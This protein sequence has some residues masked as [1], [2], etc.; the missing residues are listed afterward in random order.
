MNFLTPAFL[1]GAL[2]LALPVVLHL[3]RRRT[4]ERLPFSSLLFLSPT[5]PRLTKRSRLEDLL[6]LLLR[7][8]ALALLTFGFARPFLK[9]PSVAEPVSGQPRRLVVL[10][11]RSASMQRAGLWSAALA[12]AADILGHTTPGDQVA[13][14]AFDHEV[15]RLVSFEDWQ[16]APPGDRAALARGK[17]EALKPGWGATQLG[18]TL[19]AAAEMVTEA[20]V[21]QATPLRQIVLLSDVQE[22]GRLEKLQAY[23]WPKNLQL[24]VPPLKAKSPGN[25]GVQIVAEAADTSLTNSAVR[26]RVSNAPEATQ[27]QFQV[28]WAEA[29]DTFVGPASDVYVPPGQSR[30]VALPLPPPAAP[31][32]PPTRRVQLRGDDE[33]FDN[34]AY[35]IPPEPTTLRVLYLG[36]DAAGDARQ[37]LFFLRRALPDSPRQRVTLDARTGQA[38]LSAGDVAAAGL[39]L[40][41][42][43]LSAPTAGL[44]REAALA[45][46]TILFAPV[47]AAAGAPLATLLGVAAL[48]L[49]E[50][51]V[52]NY[53]MLAELDFE[54]PL[55]APFA[56]PRFS[57]FTKI[58]VWK[59]RVLDWASVPSARVLARFDS[60]SPALAEVPVG[61]GR[62]IILT[63]GWQPEDSQLALSTKFVPLLLSLLDYA[64]ATAGLAPAQPL[65]GEPLALRA[66]GQQVMLPD[67]TSVALAAGA[68][69]FTGTTQPGFYRVE[70]GGAPQ[71]FAVN[72]DPNESRTAPWSADVFETYGIGTANPLAAAPASALRKTQLQA[73]ESESRQKLWRWFLLATLLVLLIETALAGW[74]AR[75]ALPTEAT[76]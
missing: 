32:V 60:G 52:K 66:G 21:Q 73:A 30:V 48:P 68:T 13:V 35:V 71:W 15:N 56:D 23:D 33:P 72:L 5:P 40:V 9:N 19:I 12:Q 34:V 17:L 45:G 42:G 7:C 27:E 36:A 16:A 11:D 1:F 64:G 58:H 74:T 76:A 3:I 65:V 22:G 46:K 18:T 55:F 67:G 63:T 2:A 57:D 49:R 70:G 53:A 54:H 75:R 4:R 61:R 14:L 50:A 51:T 59:H 6:L 38:A 41:T 24:L 25:A 29:G 44:L 26:V 28:G 43:A 31:G 37:P 39:V 62:V 8:L 10:V 47:N 20:E 69:N